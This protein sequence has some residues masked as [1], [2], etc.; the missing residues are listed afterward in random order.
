M[1]P[2]EWFRAKPQCKGNSGLRKSN[3]WDSVAQA[4]VIRLKISVLVYIIESERRKP[5]VK[6]NISQDVFHIVRS[7]T[8]VTNPPHLGFLSY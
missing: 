8:W 2:C 4:V 5:L 6:R 1:V 3:L 7:F